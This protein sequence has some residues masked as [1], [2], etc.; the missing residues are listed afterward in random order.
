MH[1]QV[2]SQIA[3]LSKTFVAEF[4]DVGLD[5]IMHPHVVEEVASPEELLSAVSLS[6]NVDGLGPPRRSPSRLSSVGEVLQQLDIDIVFG[7][8]HI[9]LIHC[10]L[11]FGI[12]QGLLGLTEIAFWSHHLLERHK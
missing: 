7:V 9:V 6:A 4:A 8:D 5:S 10:S 2:F 12:V 3:F 11:Q 1:F